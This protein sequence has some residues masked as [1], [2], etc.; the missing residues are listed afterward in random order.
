MRGS[1]LAT[2][3]AA[4]VITTVVGLGGS[5]ALTSSMQPE[6][7]RPR[8]AFTSAPWSVSGDANSQGASSPVSVPEATSAAA[9]Q[10][11]SAAM[12]VVASMSESLAVG[13]QAAVTIVAE[14]HKRDT[15]A[16]PRS[17]PAPTV[18]SRPAPAKAT[19]EPEP[20]PAPLV[21]EAKAP[22]A[23]DEDALLA[24]LPGVEALEATA[25][26][27]ADAEAETQTTTEPVAPE[28]PE[29][30]PTLD[31]VAA[32]APAAAPAPVPVIGPS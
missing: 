9:R 26:R 11:G 1:A 20:E 23:P 31:P 27:L 18:D 22:E 12:R 13:G 16:A 5:V 17:Q 15:H 4:A 2:F 6:P 24:R 25:K 19:P 10:T 3:M 29:T 14:L 32:D 30:V 8:F 7:I 21:V 28:A